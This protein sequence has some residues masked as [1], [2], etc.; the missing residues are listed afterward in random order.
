[1]EEFDPI[2]RAREGDADAREALFEQWRPFV[3]L[4]LRARGRPGVGARADSSDMVQ[5]TLLRAA[6]HL[7]EF[8]GQ[9]VEEWKGWLAR[10]AGREQVRQ[11]RMHLGAG[12]RAAG[13]EAALILND[14]TGSGASRL[15][16]WLAASQT[17]PSM[18]ASRAESAVRLAAA[19][20]ALSDDHREVLTLRHL[21][22]LDFPEVAAKMG[23]SAGAVRV[24][25][26][27]ALKKLR[28]SFGTL[29]EGV[30]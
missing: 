2:R 15:S 23:R 20:D 12:R 26:V 25:W 30:G 28:D 27:R 22:G 17:S 18:A 9:S 3:K 13:R 16:Q 8:A 24:L 10:I 5:E 21:E 11:L 19:L 4:V 1:M 29:S 7:S 6:D 14:A